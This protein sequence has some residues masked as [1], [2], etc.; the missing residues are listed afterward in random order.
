M[1]IKDRSS[2]YEQMLLMNQI[3]PLRMGARCNGKNGNLFKDSMEELLPI[4]GNFTLS[5][6]DLLL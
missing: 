1:S 4:N 3:D 2:I 6:Q 5:I